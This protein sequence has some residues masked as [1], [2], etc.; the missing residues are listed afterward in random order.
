LATGTILFSLANNPY[1]CF[2]ISSYTNHSFVLANYRIQTGTQERRHAR[3]GLASSPTDPGFLPRW[4]PSS[5]GM[6][7]LPCPTKRICRSSAVSA[8]W[9]ILNMEGTRRRKVD[10]LRRG[11]P[12]SLDTHKLATPS[13]VHLRKLQNKVCYICYVFSG[14][15]ILV[16]G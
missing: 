5:G 16:L 9:R 7:R 3:S 6:A 10:T 4:I 1:I 2:N 11:I 15:L 13:M 14:S 12:N 8:S